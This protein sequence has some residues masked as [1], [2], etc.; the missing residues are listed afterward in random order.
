V[1]RAVRQS[2]RR[3]R[4]AKERLSIDD[5]NLEVARLQLEVATLRFEKGLTDNF[6]VIDAENLFNSAQISLI[7]SRNAVLLGEL[8]LLFSSALLRPEDFLPKDAK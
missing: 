4:T 5:A 1:V 2:A 3:L 6:N 7:S 8:D